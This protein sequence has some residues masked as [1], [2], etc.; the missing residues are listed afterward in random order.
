MAGLQGPAANALGIDERLY[1]LAHELA[2]VG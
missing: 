2:G 1:G